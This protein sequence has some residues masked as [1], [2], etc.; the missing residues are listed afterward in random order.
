MNRVI[1]IKVGGLLEDYSFAAFETASLALNAAA[2]GK[3]DF[4]IENGAMFFH[5]VQYLLPSF[6]PSAGMAQKNAAR[7]GAAFGVSHEWKALFFG[8]VFFVSAFG[9]FVAGRRNLICIDFILVLVI[10]AGQA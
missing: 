4:E 6:L 5:A 10:L 7:N 2:V 9:F 1:L 8:L 3:I